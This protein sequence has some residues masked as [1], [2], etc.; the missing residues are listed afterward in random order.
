MPKISDLT[1]FQGT[2]S[3]TDV[4]PVVNSSVTKKIPLSALRTNVLVN[5]VQTTGANGA[6]L[7]PQGTT[8]QRPTPATGHFR[9]NS[10]LFQFEG[11]NGTAWGAVGAGAT[12]GV[13]NPVI[14]ENDT[15]ITVD[16]TIT[17]NKN[18]MSAGPIT[19][20]NNVTLTVP[21]G[22]VYTIV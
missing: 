3:D 6:A 1:P 5:S 18:A 22:S 10:T 13:G 2:L 17:N 9:F 12:G 7:I 15:N 16:Y 20:N 8:A 11:Y 4:F 14:Y 21:A 19:V